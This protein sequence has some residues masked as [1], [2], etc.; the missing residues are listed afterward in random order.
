MKLLRVL[1]AIVTASSLAWLIAQPGYEPA[2][3][4][5]TGVSAFVGTYVAERRKHSGG[6]QSQAVGDGSVGIQAGGDVRINSDSSGR[7][8]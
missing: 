4:V 6:S 2:I 5:L 8:K 1:A 7:E 3:A